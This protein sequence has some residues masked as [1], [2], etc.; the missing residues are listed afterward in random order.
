MCLRGAAGSEVIKEQTGGGGGVTTMI[1]LLFGGHIY[2][3]NFYKKINDPSA[4]N[5]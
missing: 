1:F 2:N 5:K 3:L 4:S